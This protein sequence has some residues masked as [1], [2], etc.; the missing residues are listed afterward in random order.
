MK[1]TVIGY[2]LWGWIVVWIILLFWLSSCSKK[3]YD[4]VVND[5]LTVVR[6]DSVIVHMREVS[7]DVPV[8]QI[9]LQERIP[10]CDTLLILD[11][12]YYQSIVDIHNGQVT[13]T[14]KPSGNADGTVA[15]IPATVVVADTTHIHNENVTSNHSQQT[16]VT[17]KEEESWWKKWWRSARGMIIGI[18][19]GLIAAV[20][21]VVLWKI[22]KI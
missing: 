5:S 2:Y 10:L 16:T 22:K 11:N 1:P 19:L 4:S 14:L 6:V 20:I 15:T 7:V 18:V 13:H 21:I 3:T 17:V 8:P 12:G 9:T